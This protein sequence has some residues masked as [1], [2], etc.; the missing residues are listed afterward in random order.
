LHKQT[1]DILG[2][3]VSIHSNEVKAESCPSALFIT[4]ANK[5]PAESVNKWGHSQVSIFV[6]T[7]E[8]TSKKEEA[9]RRKKNTGAFLKA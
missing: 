7:S 3:S 5:T 6:N 9:S 2:R 4:Q 1:P 8:Q